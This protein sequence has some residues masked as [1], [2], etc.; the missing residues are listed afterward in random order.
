MLCA[1]AMSSP[2]VAPCLRR[3]TRR[4][5]S[6]AR[7]RQFNSARGHGLYRCDTQCAAV[8]ERKST[9]FLSGLTWVRIP[10]VALSRCQ[11]AGV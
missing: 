2:A 7:W 3:R 6:E 9:R 5:A 1:D 10:P 4:R 8:A 11:R